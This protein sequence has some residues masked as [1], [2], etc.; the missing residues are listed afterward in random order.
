MKNAD[1]YFAKF[2]DEDEMQKVDMV[3][4]MSKIE[5]NGKLID[6][7]RKG[8]NYRLSSAT[9]STDSNGY[10]KVIYNMQRVK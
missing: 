5:Q 6:L 10:D 2:S 1:A 7:R 9:Y 4:F 8:K 3:E